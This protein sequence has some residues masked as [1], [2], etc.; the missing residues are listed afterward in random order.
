MPRAGSSASATPAW[1]T[2]PR[3]QRSVPST[4]LTATARPSGP[5]AMSAAI[6]RPPLMG[7]RA[8]APKGSSGPRATPAATDAPRP[9]S[10]CHHTAAC[11]AEP[12]ATRGRR[13]CTQSSPRRGPPGLAPGRAER[14][15]RRAAPR[16]RSPGSPGRVPVPQCQAAT[17]S[18]RP[19]SPRK[20]RP[21][22]WRGLDSVTIGSQ[23]RRRQRP[24]ARAGDVHRLGA[25]PAARP[26]RPGCAPPGAR[27]S[28]IRPSG[29]TATW[30]SIEGRPRR[31]IPSGRLHSPPTGREEAT[32]WRDRPVPRTQTAAASPRAFSATS[33]LVASIGPDRGALGAA[34]DGARR[35]RP[36]RPAAATARTS[37]LTA[38]P[39]ARPARPTDRPSARRDQ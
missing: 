24:L 6:S 30:G 34:P 20:T 18:P 32:I 29:A 26:A 17:A 37:A 9:R 16:P 23:R 33:G 11:P 39:P 22:F 36:R 31:E 5:T 1:D 12:T 19:S 21:T 4:P 14:P 25:P 2:G 13:T 27:P 38:S 15:A 28:T 10:H 35:R 3:H 8:S 7:M